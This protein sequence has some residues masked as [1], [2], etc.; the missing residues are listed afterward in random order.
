MLGELSEEYKGEGTRYW[1]VENESGEVSGGV[2]IGRIEDHSDVCELQKLYCLPELRGTGAAQALMDTAL[3]FACKHYAKC[4]IETFDNTIAARKIYERNG[5]ERTDMRYGAT[6]HFACNILYIKDL[7]K[8]KLANP[9]SGG[10]LNLVG[11][12]R[13]L[14]HAED[15]GETNWEKISANQHIIRRVPATDKSKSYEDSGDAAK[16][17]EGGY[18]AGVVVKDNR[19]VGF[20]IDIFNED[21]YPLQ[22]FEIFLRNC[23]LSGPL[24]LSGQSDLLFVDIY[25]NRVDSID[26][27]GC[28]SMQIL[29]IQDNNI[30]ELD[31]TDL[32]ACKGI[33][34]GMNRL[35]SL[36]VSSNKKLVE[37][38]IN[39]NRFTEIDISSCPELKYFY[40]HN[41]RITELDTTANPL[42]R[43]L[44]ATGNPMR[45]ISAW[46]PQREEK[47]PL[48]LRAG[49]GGTVGL[50]FNP[51]YNAQWKETGEW[52]QSYYAY[53]DE[54]YEFEGWYDAAGT[55]VSSEAEWIDEYGAG[56]DL[57]AKFRRR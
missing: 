26:V 8:D 23:G 57:I 22:S 20:G 49:E 5:F 3:G 7:T 37:L 24:D 47:V 53:P 6:G 1:V 17:G 56:R 4:Y 19:L 14:D 52:Q 16:I 25:H 33:D 43:H 55:K 2:G 51:V 10:M 31:V 13:F 54:D 35:S 18:P 46:A 36:D 21:I 41:N 9:L 45:S 30:C 28:R 40:C 11:I 29:G 44:N 50:R 38:Y 42:L 27:S 12:K 39:D 32:A 48:R 34:A 15:G